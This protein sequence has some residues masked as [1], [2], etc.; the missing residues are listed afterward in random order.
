MMVAQGIRVLSAAALVGHTAA[1][2]TSAQAPQAFQAS[3]NPGT[4]VIQLTQDIG[5]EG[6]DT[7]LLRIYGDGRVLVHFPVY[8]R[9]AGDYGLRL[10]STELDG[11]LR[12][13]VQGGLVDFSVEG[14]REE[15]RQVRGARRRD[16][17][18]T[19]G[20]VVLTTRSD[21]VVVSIDVRLERYTDADGAVRQN[22][23]TRASWSG[24]QFDAA[25][26]PGVASLQ[27]LATI[28]RQLI[29]LTNH[30]DLARVGP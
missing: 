23:E 22:V 10:D 17:L 11:L 25:E 3:E 30:P 18:E 21:D 12:T 7:P 16:A 26:F 8:M 6:D 1:V 27:S 4:V 14:V 24:L 15:I 20:P 13:F 19:A 9:R 5:V 28:E 29:G 2:V